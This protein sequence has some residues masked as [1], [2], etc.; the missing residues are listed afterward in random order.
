MMSSFLKVCLSNGIID[1][2]L[3]SILFPVDADYNPDAA[4]RG[5]YEKYYSVYSAGLI[6]TPY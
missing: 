4:S 1:Q 2:Y 3:G 6:D 5:G